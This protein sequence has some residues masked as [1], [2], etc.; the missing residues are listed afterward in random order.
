M[1]RFK[2]G[3]RRYFLH[4][5]RREVKEVKQPAV[6]KVREVEQLERKGNHSFPPTAEFKNEYIF[7]KF[8]SLRVLE[9]AT[10]IDD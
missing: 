7:A 1:I 8:L 6:Q 3:D 5:A 9:D 2:A 4:R 10:D